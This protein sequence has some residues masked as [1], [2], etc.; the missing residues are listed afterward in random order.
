MALKNFF[1]FASTVSRLSQS[2]KPRLRMASVLLLPRRN[3]LSSLAPPARVLNPW[4]SHL[5]FARA[6]DSRICRRE[7]RRV[8]QGAR[9]DET[10]GRRALLGGASFIFPDCFAIAPFNSTIV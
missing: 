1:R 6:G 8:T 7:V 4:T 2:V 10:R 5:S 9:A 3:V